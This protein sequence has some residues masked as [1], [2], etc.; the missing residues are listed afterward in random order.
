MNSLRGRALSLRTYTEPK[1]RIGELL[2]DDGLV[3]GL[4]LA[5][6]LLHQRECGGKIIDI[7]VA[8]GAI[9][10]DA[11]VDFLGRQPG[12]P[13]LMLCNYDVKRDVVSLVPKELAVKHEVFPIETLG[14]VLTLGMVCPLDKAAISELEKITQHKVRPILCLPEDIRSA[15]NRYYARKDEMVT[16]SW[17]TLQPKHTDFAILDRK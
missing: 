8:L 4:D 1:K 12:I 16:L 9:D 2:V 10:P 17:H 6:A 13:S 15:I 5:K 14:R 3:T 7:L 11:V